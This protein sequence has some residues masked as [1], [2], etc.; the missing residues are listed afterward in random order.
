M[1]FVCVST[2]CVCMCVLNPNNANISPIHIF[3]LHRNVWSAEENGTV[4]VVM[5]LIYIHSY[6]DPYNP[7]NPNNPANP[8]NPNI[9]IYI[10]EIFLVCIIKG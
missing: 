10:Y 9:Y 8:D 4:C 2:V 3:L 1:R 7:D 6:D 5:T